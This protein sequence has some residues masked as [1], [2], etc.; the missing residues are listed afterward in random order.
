M[1]S[2]NDK[3]GSPHIRAAVIAGIFGVI[4]ACISVT[5]LIIIAFINNGFI[6]AG[7][8]NSNPPNIQPTS[9]PVI[10]SPPQTTNDNQNSDSFIA[11]SPLIING[12]S[13]SVPTSNSP[14]CVAS[15]ATGYTSGNIDYDLIVPKGW[16]IVWDS[17]K[18]YWTG[19]NYENDGLLIVY[20]SLQ[21]KVTIVNGE[22]CAVPVEWKDFAISLRAN[23]V[24]KPSRPQFSIGETP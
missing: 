23:A 17:W 11:S 3:D 18:A 12:K 7:A 14:Y 4:A 15:E 21:G 10:T 2:Q 16:V 6:F 20:G 5:G 22:Y 9:E 8:G 19:G 24:T 13:Y 1:N